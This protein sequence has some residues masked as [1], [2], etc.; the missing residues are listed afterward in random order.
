[1]PVGDGHR[2]SDDH[3]TC[4]RED[5]EVADEVTGLRSDDRT[6]DEQA[7][8]GT[9]GRLPGSATIGHEHMI[10]SPMPVRMARDVCA[11]SGTVDR[12]NDRHDARG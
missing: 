2:Q 11:V 5:A 1:M 10:S 3:N 12:G 4:A 7:D 6:G 9:Y 8:Q